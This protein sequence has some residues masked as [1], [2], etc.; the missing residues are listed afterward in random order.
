MTMDMQAAVQAFLVEGRELTQEFEQGLLR[1]EQGHDPNDV[2]LINAMFRAAHTIKGSAGIVGIDSLTRFTHKV[3]T[4]LDRVRSGEPLLDGGM[5]T[6]LLRC[7]DHINRLLDLA[8]RGDPLGQE[9]SG[10]EAALLAGLDPAASEQADA[11]AAVSTGASQTAS[12]R[13]GADAAQGFRMWA[14]FGRDSLRDG[15]DP[16]S[17]L[18]Y[19]SERVHIRSSALVTPHVPPLDQIDAED[20]WVAMALEADSGV[21]DDAREAFEFFLDRTVMVI[22]PLGASLAEVHEA[23]APVRVALGDV[24]PTEWLDSGLLK[25]GEWAALPALP[26]AEAA[27]SGGGWE[28]HVP[29]LVSAA[30][31]ATSPTSPATTSTATPAAPAASA[32]ASGASAS[33]AGGTARFVRV[34]AERLDEL[35]VQVGELVIASAGVDVLAR[36]TRNTRLQEAVSALMQLVDGIQSGTLQLR[37]VPIGETF[38]RFQR[39]VRDVSRELGK[40]IQLELVGGDTELDKAMV[41]R[42]SDPLMH[43]VRNAMD[44][45]L[46]TPE[47]RRRTGKPEMGTLRL[48]AFHES[49]S[50]VVEVSDDGRGLDRDRILNKA[51]QKGLITTVEGLT[52]PEVFQLIFEPGFSTAETITNLSGRGVGMDVVKKSIEALR[53]AI[54]LNSRKGAGT[55][56]Q[57][58][59]PLTLAIIDGFMVGVGP[60]RFIVP[61]DVVVECIELPPDALVPDRPMYLNLR[62]EVLPYVSLRQTFQIEGDIA[63][64]PSVVVVRSGEFKTGI[65]VDTLHG[66]IQTVIKPMSGIFKHMKSICGTSILGTGDI[67]LILDVNQLVQGSV[68]KA[69]RLAAAAANLSASAASLAATSTHHL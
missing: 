4:L 32:A 47:E 11:S 56:M 17:A 66:E 53:G 54:T 9:A 34:P 63:R 25:A 40:S 45:G 5:I 8:E 12:C 48:R 23:L 44:H 60:D 16:A 41:E 58:R 61:L 62:G 6:Q 33:P 68:D 42:I 59:L 35:I 22:L 30:A 39:V 14:V 31:A 29:A 21:I 18:I 2:N 20:C 28:P 43:L 51:L 67:A 1:L 26:N 46:E 7:C 65:L 19:L 36:D 24:T 10:D 52:D 27:A 55:L 69:T 15:M 57:M 37:M 3:E 13:A 49:G 64:R 38:S 50:V